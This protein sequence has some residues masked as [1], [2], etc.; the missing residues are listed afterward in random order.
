MTE[1][2]PYTSLDYLRKDFS[3]DRLVL[4]KY[5]MNQSSDYLIQKDFIFYFMI[6]GSAKFQ[7]GQ[8]YVELEKGNL[9]A[10]LPNQAHRFIVNQQENLLY[11]QMRFPLRLLLVASTE[12]HTFFDDLKHLDQPLPITQIPAQNQVLLMFYCQEL[13]HANPTNNQNLVIALLTYCVYLYDRNQKNA[14]TIQ[15]NKT[16]AGLVLNYLQQNYSKKLSVVQVSQALGISSVEV[17]RII[18]EN[19]GLS[20]SRFS[21]NLRSNNGYNA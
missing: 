20:F 4:R 12:G 13:Q 9:I 2:F 18:K 21:N 15:K 19:T 8:H 17:Q 10:V 5:S 1:H 3:S 7:F 16:L 14:Q 6:D 11:Y